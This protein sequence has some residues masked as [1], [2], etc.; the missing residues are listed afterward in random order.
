MALKK[1]QEID[2]W[3][4]ALTDDEA[5]V[6][7]KHLIEGIDWGRIAHVYKERWGAENE[8]SERTLK[9]YQRRAIAK[10]KRL[11]A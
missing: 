4:S 11:G 2:I 8:K 10:I 3:L 7:K 1:K 9:M 6:V 5:F